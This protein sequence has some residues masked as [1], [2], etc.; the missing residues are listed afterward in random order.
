MSEK[1]VSNVSELLEGFV[2]TEIPRDCHISHIAIDSREVRNHGMFIAM[3]G[4][5]KDGHA[6]V[7]DA[8]RQGASVI[9]SEET[10]P[11]PND[12]DCLLI[13]C[14]DL[15]KKLG[16]IVARFYQYDPSSIDLIAVTGTNGKTSIAYLLAR[17]LEGGYIGTLGVGMPHDLMTSINT[18]PSPIV[19]H[20]VLQSLKDEGVA[21][22]VMEVSSHAM[23]QERVN[24]LF[25][26][27]AVF[28]NLS[29]EHLDYHGDMAQYARA[30]FSLFTKERIAHAVVN[31]DCPW[32]NRLVS[33]LASQ[34][35]LTYAIK[36]K[37]A[38]IYVKQFEQS[39][40][41]IKASLMTPE[42]ECLLESPLF[43]EFNLYNL[44]AVLGVL[45]VKRMP[46]AKALNCIKQASS[47]IGRMEVVHHRPTFVIDYAHTPDA[48]E[49]A[50]SNLKTLCEGQLWCVFGCG[51][52]RDTVKR[53]LMGE[54]VERLADHIVITNDNPRFEEGQAIVNDILKGIKDPDRV[55]IELDR[56]K[57]IRHCFRH[58][59]PNDVVLI[60]GK[61]H[62]TYQIINGETFHFSDH[63]V[64]KQLG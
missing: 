52:N 25:Y 5:A 41:G 46:L 30:K 27:V 51:G 42:G 2:T 56:E 58:A 15:R 39:L 61:G 64:V 24:G 20:G 1:I 23:S 57:A 50:L 63:E 34:P 16:F 26:N 32:G 60:A 21:N 18:T 29:H 33:Q 10:V 36:N 37:Q 44:L 6:F 11:L 7:E 55:S 9:L 48:L 17:L 28:T 13:L 47:I 19:I 49:K 35:V 38:D 22:C 40:M 53:A 8:I 45:L 3:K 62:E 12:S 4:N 43:C 59:K 14:N 54:I 31:I